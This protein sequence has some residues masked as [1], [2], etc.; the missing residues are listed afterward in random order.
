MEMQ[1]RIQ[2][3]EVT[4]ADIVVEAPTTHPGG[5]VFGP[6]V[7]YQGHGQ[8]TRT[9]DDTPSESIGRTLAV[10]R[11]LQDVGKKMTA[12]AW[13][14][15]R[16]RDERKVKPLLPSI[17]PA[18]ELREATLA[19]HREV[20]ARVPNRQDQED[21][22][23][24]LGEHGVRF[25]LAGGGLVEIIESEGWLYIRALDGVLTVR[26]LDERSVYMRPVG[27]TGSWVPTVHPARGIRQRPKARPIGS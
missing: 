24:V 10:G 5:S 2:D 23:N 6:P 11:A 12:A 1:V 25:R 27:R 7:K 18:R 15:V 3:G 13:K 22:V 17:D 16:V 4:T 20:I 14:V 8:A 26:P 21:S 19:R 9:A